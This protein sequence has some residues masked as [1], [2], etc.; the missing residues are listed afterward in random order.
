MALLYGLIIPV[1]RLFRVRFNDFSVLRELISST[2][3]TVVGQ[4]LTVS[5]PRL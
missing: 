1:A 3:L 5:F 2:G 4:I